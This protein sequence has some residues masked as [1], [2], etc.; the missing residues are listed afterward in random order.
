MRWAIRQN[1]KVL[2]KYLL[3]HNASGKL[4]N[5]TWPAIDWMNEFPDDWDTEF[6]IPFLQHAQRLGKDR[7]IIGTQI[8][9][10]LETFLGR[11]SVCS[12]DALDSRTS[13]DPFTWAMEEQ[14]GRLELR[15]VSF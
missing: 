12:Y 10:L 15:A 6:V 4:E 9:K 14:V 8:T 2:S 7:N 11:F 5:G 13:R 3:Q 1:D